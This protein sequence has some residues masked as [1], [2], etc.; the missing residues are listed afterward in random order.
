MASATRVLPWRHVARL[1]RWAL[2]TVA[3][4]VTEAVTCGFAHWDLSA[5]TPI[6][7]DEMSRQKR[8]LV[9]FAFLGSERTARLQGICC[10]M[11]AL[12]RRHQGQGAPSGLGVGRYL[13]TGTIWTH[14]REAA[15]LRARISPMRDYFTC[16]IS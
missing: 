14:C 5:V 10:G 6:G 4:A 1:S 7:I 12:Y 3:Q 15:F 16:W 13:S 8:L 11:A 2:G 9:F